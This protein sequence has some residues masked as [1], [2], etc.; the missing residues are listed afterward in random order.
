MNKN[1]KV[2][3]AAGIIFLLAI[4]VGGAFWLQDK[5]IH[6]INKQKNQAPETRPV[7]VKNEIN[8]END[9]IVTS[10]NGLLMLKVE[11]NDNMSQFVLYNKNERFVLSEGHSYPN[12]ADAMDFVIFK[13]PRFSPKENYIIVDMSG[14]EGDI[15]WV[16][17]VMTREKIA[18]GAIGKIHFT[19]D[20]KYF[21]YCSQMYQKEAGVKSVP[22]FKTKLDIFGDIILPDEIY[23]RNDNFDILDCFYD[24]KNNQISFKLEEINNSAEVDDKIKTINFPVMP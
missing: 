14:Y 23:E 3:I 9:I 11:N 13:N 4:M 22:E 7:F 21:Y 12:N 5:N 18:Y 24:K 16:Y 17:S 8:K 1:I 10:T 20:E 6:E 19:D 15:S 2:E